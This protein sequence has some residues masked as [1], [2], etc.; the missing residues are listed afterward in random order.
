[1]KNQ[2]ETWGHIQTEILNFHLNQ[3][4]NLPVLLPD[5]NF[6]RRLQLYDN[7]W[8]WTEKTIQSPLGLASLAF[9]KRRRGRRILIAA[10]RRVQD[11]MR[12]VWGTLAFPLIAVLLRVAACCVREHNFF[13]SPLVYGYIIDNK[14][15]TWSLLHVLFLLSSFSPPWCWWSP[16]LKVEMSTLYGVFT[17]KIDANREVISNSPFLANCSC[18]FRILPR[19]SGLLEQCEF[20]R[21]VLSSWSQLTSKPR[22]IQ[23]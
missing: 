11:G 7:Y 17:T 22:F 10:Q 21:V 13:N 3:T 5:P 4:A 16:V 23:W 15:A 19:S 20:G 1:M 6:I 14:T 2:N 9:K 8:R 18:L 12:V